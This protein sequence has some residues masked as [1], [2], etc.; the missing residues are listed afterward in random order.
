MGAARLWTELPA[1]ITAFSE[2]ASA[3]GR[4]LQPGAA[5]T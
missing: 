1:G 4:F 3:I 5:K 2:F